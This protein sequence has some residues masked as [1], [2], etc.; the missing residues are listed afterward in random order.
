[1]QQELSA[2]GSVHAD[3]R[4]QPTVISS[5]DSARTEAEAEDKR[6]RDNS[7]SETQKRK[8]VSK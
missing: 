3:A 1:M 4:S 2:M 7:E 6:V 8:T 5:V